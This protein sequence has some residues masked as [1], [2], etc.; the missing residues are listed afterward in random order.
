MNSGR[1]AKARWPLRWWMV[2]FVLA[3]PAFLHYLVSPGIPAARK[4]FL[5]ILEGSKNSNWLIGWRSI[6]LK[7]GRCS[8]FKVRH[9]HGCR[10]IQC[11]EGHVQRMPGTS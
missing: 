4:D 6:R 11:V 5:C 9:I 8:V 10:A 2:D 7:V 3:L 1:T